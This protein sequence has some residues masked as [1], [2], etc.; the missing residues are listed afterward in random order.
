MT[1]PFG[2]RVE[3]DRI[4]LQAVGLIGGDPVWDD[5]VSVLLQELQL[6]RTDL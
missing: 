6:L 4:P 3:C 2:E 5:D 1:V